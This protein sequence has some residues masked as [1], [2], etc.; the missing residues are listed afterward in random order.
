MGINKGA[1]KLI[2]AFHS[3]APE[4]AR[5][6][7]DMAQVYAERHPRALL[8]ERHLVEGADSFPS[9]QEIGETSPTG[10]CVV[11]WSDRRVIWSNRAYKAYF[12]DL[13]LRPASIG[14]RIDEIV[15]GFVESGMDAIFERVA[16]THE[17]FNTSAYRVDLPAGPTYWD[18]S[19]SVL[20][21]AA[22]DEVSLLIQ[23]NRTLAAPLPLYSVN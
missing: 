17:A 2:Q 4:A 6:L 15:P 7:L 11:R 5:I 12:A 16:A 3:M 8:P 20:P 22:G 14:A 23:M 18:W 9:V 19:L 13:A 10:M 21:T 1:S